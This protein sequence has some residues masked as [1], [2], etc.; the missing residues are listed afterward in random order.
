MLTRVWKPSERRYF[1][2]Y[3]TE[4]MLLDILDIRVSNLSF[5]FVSYVSMR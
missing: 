5:F 3:F 2:C 4:G 1:L